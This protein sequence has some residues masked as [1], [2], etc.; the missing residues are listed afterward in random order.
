M[1]PSSGTGHPNLKRQLGLTTASLVVVANMIGAGIFGN[2]GEI[3]S[4]VGDPWLVMLLWGLGGVFALAGALSYAELAT[5]W[6]HAG[7]E[8]V[9]LKRIFGRLWSFLSGW[10]SFIVGFAAPA[11]W[12]AIVSGEYLY[13]LFLSIDPASPLAVFFRDPINRKIYAAALILLFSGVHIVGVKSGSLVQNGLTIVKLLIVGVFAIAGFSVLFAGATH[14]AAALPPMQSGG[15]Q[16]SALAIGL[17][18]VSYAYS[19]WNGAAYMAEEVER[20]ERTLPRALI[21]STLATMGLFLALNLVYY[22]AAPASEI[23]GKH[24]VA[25]IA[26]RRIFG[27]EISIFFNLAFCVILL[28]SISAY[29]MI[30]PRVYFAM[31]RDNLFFSYAK[32]ID[33][34]F[35]TPVVSI[36]LQAI[37]SIIYIFTGTYD[38][39][40]T[41][42]GFALL[43][44]PVLT[45]I[46]LV[47]HRYKH[48]DLD[49]PYRTPWF[50][51]TPLVFIVS[52]IF[53]MV[54]S[55]MDD[56]A[57]CLRAILISVGGIPVFYVWT[58]V[59]RWIE[60]R[61]AALVPD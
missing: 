3:Q 27:P 59:H 61:R 50:P 49:R 20:P 24:T 15:L 57:S 42:M 52:S 1:S 8:Y 54:G 33:P 48:P 47:V 51:L 26:A 22:W 10:V 25:A 7:G 53:I 34:R 18:W 12:A 45:V 6:P 60:N 46:G 19:G 30:G 31:A 23:A 9:Y 16:W 43:I 55:F 28:S 29:V 36:A 2:T 21:L 56:P 32:Q 5:L 39:I 17:L 40:M 38:S 58:A 14:E 44:F 11:A 37:L 35:G 4:N 41:Y 13:E